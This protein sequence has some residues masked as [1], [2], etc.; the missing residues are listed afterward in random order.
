MAAG[1]DYTVGVAQAGSPDRYIDNEQHTNS[2]GT[3]VARQKVSAPR[4]DMLLSGLIRV[5]HRIGL[6]VDTSARQR[7]SVENIASGLT[8]GTVTTVSGVTTVTTVTTCSTVTNLAQ[9]GGR[10]ATPIAAAQ[11]NAAAI[12]LRGRIAVS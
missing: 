7:V 6:T 12:A 4:S 5:L 10:D 3:A 1:D 11:M 9:L 2:D 8:L